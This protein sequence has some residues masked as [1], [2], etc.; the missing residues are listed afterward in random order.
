[1]LRFILP[2][3]LL[4]SACVAE[5]PAVPPVVDPDPDACGTSALQGLLGKDRSILEAMKFSQPV[6]VIEPGMAVTLDYSAGRLNILLDEHDRIQQ[7][8]CG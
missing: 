8:T 4:L 6:R 2:T 5:V 1:M 3:T 7:V